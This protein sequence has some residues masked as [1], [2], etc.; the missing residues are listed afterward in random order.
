MFRLRFRGIV[1]ALTVLAWLAA[2]AAPVAAQPQT[3]AI[4][5][6][7]NDA[8]GKPV[9]SLALRL[10][11]FPQ[12]DLQ[13]NDSGQPP[14]PAT[15]QDGRMQTV[16]TAITDANG[17]F[18]MTNL[19]PGDYVLVGGNKS[20]GFVYHDVSVQPGQTTTVQLTLVKP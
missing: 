18:S 17:K 9:P 16:A 11:R 19:K 8:S 12:R 7:V 10:Q 13:R 6:Q 2:P 14:D 5:G 3:G 20:I 15:L 1:L 4:Q